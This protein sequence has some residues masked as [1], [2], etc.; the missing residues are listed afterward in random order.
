MIIPDGYIVIKTGWERESYVIPPSIY[1]FKVTKD[2]RLH[3]PVR[4]I[5][6]K[7]D[8]K[9]IDENPHRIYDDGTEEFD[10]IYLKYQT[11]FASK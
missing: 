4:F 8:S 5:E 10:E 9:E 2:K 7:L 6:I 1:N 11:L 3:D